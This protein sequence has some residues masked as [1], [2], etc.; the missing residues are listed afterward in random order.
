MSIFHAPKMTNNLMKKS[1][2]YNQ[3]IGTHLSSFK[4]YEDLRII[5]QVAKEEAG[6][7]PAFWR[8]F[9]QTSRLFKRS[10]D[11]LRDRYVNFL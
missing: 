1:S 5:A 6:L 3:W 10:P 4:I 8:K 11:A 2:I 9:Q 7:S